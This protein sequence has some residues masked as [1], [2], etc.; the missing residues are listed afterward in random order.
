MGINVT[1]LLSPCIHTYL[2]DVNR[3]QLCNLL[4]CNYS[5]AC[6]QTQFNI[7]L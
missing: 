4:P 6:K 7:I 2:T 5:D 3:L 1:A